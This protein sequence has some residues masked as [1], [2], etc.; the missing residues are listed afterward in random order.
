MIVCCFAGRYPQS[1]QHL[2]SA[3]LFQI[4]IRPA[5]T[6][7]KIIFCFRLRNR[8]HLLESFVNCFESSAQSAVVKFLF[9]FSKTMPNSSQDRVHHFVF[10]LRRKHRFALKSPS[11]FST[12]LAQPDSVPEGNPSF[13]NLQWILFQICL[14]FV[15]YGEQISNVVMRTQCTNVYNAYLWFNTKDCSCFLIKW[16]DVRRTIWHECCRAKPSCCTECMNW[17]LRPRSTQNIWQNI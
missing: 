1:L 11:R 4:I 3:C 2:F 16:C 9:G 5:G 8:Q 17:N 15:F 13:S 7:S 10:R 14:P 6:M 12:R